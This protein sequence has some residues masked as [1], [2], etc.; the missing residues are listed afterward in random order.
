[1]RRDDSRAEYEIVRPYSGLAVNCR[2]DCECALARAQRGLEP[3]TT[4][5]LKARR[6][7]R[8]SAERKARVA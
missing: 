6:L 1:M 5:Q 4:A 8:A 2:P 7:A 3:L